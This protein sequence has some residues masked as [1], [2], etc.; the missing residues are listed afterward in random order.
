MGGEKHRSVLSGEQAMDNEA[1]WSQ[2]AR[3]LLGGGLHQG[4]LL[5]PHL[6]A[7]P[8]WDSFRTMMDLGGGPGAYCM[9]FVSEHSHMRGVV[10]DQKTVAV[11]A[12]KIINEYGMGERVSVQAG[13]Y[14]KDADLGS[15]YGFIWSC[16]T[17]NFAKG[18]LEPLF[19]KIRRAL[20]P[21]GVFASFHPSV[22][23]TDREAWQMVVGFA[24][25][26][27][28]GMDMQ[29][30]GDEIA[31]AMLAA[32]FQSVQSKEIETVHGLQR[33]DL[34]RKAGG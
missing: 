7:L 32:G 14:I 25:Y 34:A 18:Q 28:L 24:P 17:L 5:L 4:Q 6:K 2:A 21:G 13:D 26:A 15:G 27:M 3:A 9:V 16:A 23:R 29:F 1:R 12:Q 20:E 11:E 10:F 22:S 31:Q 30:Y 19:T 33:L 8:E